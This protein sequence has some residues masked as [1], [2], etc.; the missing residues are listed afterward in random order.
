MHGVCL[1]FDTRKIESS[2]YGLVAWKLFW[3]YVKE[4]DLL[5]GTVLLSGDLVNIDPL[6]YGIAILSENEN[7]IDGLEKY[8]SSQSEFEA[9]SFKDEP[10]ITDGRML[11][12]HLIDAG[13]INDKGKFETKDNPDDVHSTALEALQETA[14]YKYNKLEPQAKEIVDLVDLINLCHREK[15]NI[16]WQSSQ[17]LPMTKKS[18]TLF[19][20][21]TMIKEENL[22]ASDGEKIKI[23]DT[24]ISMA[25]AIAKPQAKE[26]IKNKEPKKIYVIDDLKGM[27]NDK[28][29]QLSKESRKEI[30]LLIGE[31]DEEF[32]E[33]YLEGG[34]SITNNEILMAIRRVTGNP[35]INNNK[36][37]NEK[38]SPPSNSKTKD[39]KWWQLWNK[40]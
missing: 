4:D 5:P 26:D 22:L 40:N 35:I 30:I 15:K 37:N 25:K 17:F 11:N 8:F 3:Q 13:K 12:T 21:L 38:T 20:S 1:V 10:I 24:F 14:E 27:T 31:H 16:L 2:Y 39:K 18:Y 28:L 29:N 33:K 34:D 6:N 23:L 32:M 9:I 36:Q 19:E 7:L